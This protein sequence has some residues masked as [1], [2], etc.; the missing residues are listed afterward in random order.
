MAAPIVN[1]GNFTHS[2]GSAQLPVLKEIFVAAMETYANY[3]EKLGK[4]VPHDRDI[5][6][7]SELWGFNLLP[8]V[9]EG[10]EITFSAA[11][12][13]AS[14]TL[15]VAKY[16]RGISWS[17]E[18]EEDGKMDLVGKMVQLLAKSAMET[19]HVNFMDL[20][21]NGFGTQTAPDG[22]A[23]F[24]ASHTLPSG[25]TYSNIITGADLSATSLEAALVAFE[26]QFVDDGGVVQKY[27]PKVL[28]VAPQNR[29]IAYE[30]LNSIGRADTADN[31]INSFKQFGLEVVVS[32]HLTD[33]DSFY[34]MGDTSSHGL[35]IIE[36]KPLVTM[37]A[38]SDWGYTNDSKAY[39]AKFRE[40][41]GAMSAQAIIGSQG[42]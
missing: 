7:G 8:S 15:T 42:A 6:Q 21:N 2:Y 35:R 34:I 3:R 31:N 4:V 13:G 16:A 12:Q 20:F 23:I 10:S 33:T 41:Y 26:T 37:Y 25:G 9:A 5:Y 22:V 17:E 19:Q 38:G 39:K 18:F 28:L 24:S 1:R 36:R 30:L 29:F 32:Q 27:A 40:A 11:N 14:K